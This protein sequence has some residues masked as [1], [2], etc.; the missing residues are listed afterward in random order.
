MKNGLIID[1]YGNKFWYQSNLLHR[2]DG[3][4]VEWKNGIKE[5]YKEG[6]Y[7]RED[8][9]AVEGTFSKGWFQN[10]KRHRLDGPAVE[11]FNG[12]IKNWYFQGKEIRCKSQKEFE[13]LIKLRYFW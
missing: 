5:W 2:L 8:G 11:Y 6:E 13:K 9:P 4:A 10:G 12:E 1:H 7:H 3:P